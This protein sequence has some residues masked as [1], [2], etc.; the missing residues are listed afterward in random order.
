MSAADDLRDLLL[1]GE[2]FAGLMASAPAGTNDWKSAARGSWDQAQRVSDSRH[3]ASLAGQMVAAAVRGADFGLP[4]GLPAELRELG[5]RIGDLQERV[6]AS[7]LDAGATAILQD[8]QAAR[9]I[10][11]YPTAG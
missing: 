2:A 10:T 9:G 1:A 7:G 8:Y 3:S 4:D 11:P 5:D 6:V